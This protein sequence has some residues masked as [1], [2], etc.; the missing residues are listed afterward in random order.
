MT[1]GGKGAFGC[2]LLLS[3]RIP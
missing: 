1:L 3:S 2:G